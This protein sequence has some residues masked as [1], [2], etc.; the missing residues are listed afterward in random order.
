MPEPDPFASPFHHVRLPGEPEPPAG[1]GYLGPMPG[2]SEPNPYAAPV[3]VPDPYAAANP[4]AVPVAFPYATSAA[5]V[6]VKAFE[7]PVALLVSSWSWLAATVLVVLVL[8]ALFFLDPDVHAAELYDESQG[9]PDPMSRA[10]AEIVAQITPMF[11]AAALAVVAVPY[12]V[13][14]VKLRGGRNW[15][16]VVLAVLG[17]FGVVFGL[18]MLAAFSTGAVEYVNWLVGTVWA[19][20]F[21]AAVLLGIVAMFVPPANAYVRAVSAR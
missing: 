6:H 3:E 13:A 15:P 11:F 14:A 10:E 12:V 9:G 7:R 17:G 2:A 5:D 8:P 4:Y 16:R 19:L 18:G 21:L 1:Y 20:L